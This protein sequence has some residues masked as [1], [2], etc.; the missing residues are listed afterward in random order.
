MVGT[1][2]RVC[3]V[4][5]GPAGLSLARAL[6][7]LGVAYDQYERHTD[8]GG[9]WDLDNPGTPMY[10][11]AHFISSRKMSGFFDHPMPDSFP[12]Y[13]SN[14]QVL[15]YTRGFADAYGLRD[16]IRFGTPVTSV[17]PDG[18]GWRVV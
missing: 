8:V 1:G 12:D 6:R 2:E 3:I 4:G 7:K 17:Q 18:D 10:E 13:P 9:I 5:A 11:S 14:R 15:A 16:A